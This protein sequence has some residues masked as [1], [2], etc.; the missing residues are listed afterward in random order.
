MSQF[1]LEQFYLFIFLKKYVPAA[2][3]IILNFEIT[4]SLSQKST[5]ESWCIFMKLSK[6]T[7]YILVF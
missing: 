6:I 2:K 3:N 1:F 4:K 7:P 5:L